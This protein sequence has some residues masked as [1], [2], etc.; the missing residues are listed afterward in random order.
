MP[1][2][3]GDGGGGGG[4]GGSGEDVDVGPIFMGSFFI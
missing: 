4:G 1:G 3:I 2:V